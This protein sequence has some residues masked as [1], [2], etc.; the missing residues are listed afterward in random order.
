MTIPAPS[1]PRPDVSATERML[2]EAVTRRADQ[3]AERDA[4]DGERTSAT[5]APTLTQDV[6]TPAA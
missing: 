2:D 1:G 3:R 6:L 5:R 4:L